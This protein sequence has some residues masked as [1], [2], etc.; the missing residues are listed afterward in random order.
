MLL[1]PALNSMDWKIAPSLTM[2]LTTVLRRF[3][4]KCT[5]IQRHMTHICTNLLSGLGYSTRMIDSVEK[6]N[7]R[8]FC[9]GTGSNI[10]SSRASLLPVNRRPPPVPEDSRARPEEAAVRARLLK[11]DAL[12][13]RNM[14]R[15]IL[16]TN[17]PPDGLPLARR[18][19]Q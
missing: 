14:C 13:L 15:T 9:P 18:R 19:K 5:S 17:R 7:G 3:Q 4:D 2:C 12:C 16:P 1:M 6:L 8:R 11:V 10:S